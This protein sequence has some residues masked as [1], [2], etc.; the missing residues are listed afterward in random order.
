MQWDFKRDP[1]EPPPPQKK[2]RQSSPRFVRPRGHQRTCAT[3]DLVGG[4]EN[5]DGSREEGQVSTDGTL[6]IC[7]C[8]SLYTTD[9]PDHTY[10][11]LSL[12]RA[13]MAYSYMMSAGVCDILTCLSSHYR[14]CLLNESLNAHTFVYTLQPSARGADCSYARRGVTMLPSIYRV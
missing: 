11:S 3:T 6:S 10:L 2:H 13:R 7:V 1:T 5:R 9:G 14:G 8:V 4:L 12:S